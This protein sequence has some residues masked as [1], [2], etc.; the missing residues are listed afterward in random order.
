MAIISL[1]DEKDEKRIL[2]PLSWGMDL[3]ERKGFEKLL[4][5]WSDETPKAFWGRSQGWLTKQC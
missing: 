1:L 2:L 5:I 4:M 3:K